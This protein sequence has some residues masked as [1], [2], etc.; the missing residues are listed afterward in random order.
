MDIRS[1]GSYPGSELSN[2]A[3]HR[4]WLDG[5]ECGS[6]EGLLQ[7]LKFEEVPLQAKIRK[8]VGK[9][10]KRRGGART[11]TGR[12]SRYYGGKASQ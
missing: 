10:A 8:M 2:F 6:M 11:Q 1:S 9:D 5:V 4:F 7:S 3:P 12:N